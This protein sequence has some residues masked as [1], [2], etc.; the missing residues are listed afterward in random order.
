MNIKVL[1]AC[2]LVAH[3]ISAIFMLLVIIRQ[4]GLSKK[5]VQREL[6]WFRRLLFL[7]ACGIFFGNFSP[8]FIDSLTA[9]GSVTRSTDRVN[10]IGVVYS[11]S[12]AFVFTLTAFLVWAVYRMAA[13]TILIVDH[14]ENHLVD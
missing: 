9:L 14:E 13:S 5:R 3:L 7:L 2:L 12:N 10:A 11:V 8:I 1:A 4:Y 6:I